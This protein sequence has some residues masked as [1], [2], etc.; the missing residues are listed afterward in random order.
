MTYNLQFMWP[1]PPSAPR[2]KVRDFRSLFFCL[3]GNGRN[4]QMLL[5]LQTPCGFH[6]FLRGHKRTPS[7]TLWSLFLLCFLC[8][9]SPS[10]AAVPKWAGRER[11]H[12]PEPPLKPRPQPLLKNRGCWWATLLSSALLSLAK[13][14]DVE[15][16]CC[17]ISNAFHGLILCRWILAWP[18][19][20]QNPST[21]GISWLF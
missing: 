6:S 20:K 16:H 5:L 10:L 15:I 7:V 8:A 17:R 9:L 11:R 12:G 3:F 2:A 1:L 14:R 21:P 13:E 4:P 18:V 19:L